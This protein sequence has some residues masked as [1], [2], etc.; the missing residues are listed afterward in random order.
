MKLIIS[1]EA[2][3]EKIQFIYTS[4]N[5]GFQ[6]KSVILILDN[7]GFLQSLSDDWSL[8]KV[9]S[10]IVNISPEEAKN[11]AI[12]YAR[13]YSWTVNGEIIGN[14]TLVEETIS[15]E[16]WPHS[17]DHPLVLMPYWYVIINLDRVYPDRIDRLA[18]GLWADNGEVS[19]IQTLSW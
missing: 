3:I 12:D 14:F 10:T 5:I 13:D 1:N 4:N 7:Y 19:T 9:G 16:L 11:I 6:A 8:Y 15:A 2:N 17:R 18:V